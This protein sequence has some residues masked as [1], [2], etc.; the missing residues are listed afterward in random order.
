[1]MDILGCQRLRIQR[2]P[3]QGS[4]WPV[5]NGDNPRRENPR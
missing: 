4:R 3:P 1:M 2:R 5:V